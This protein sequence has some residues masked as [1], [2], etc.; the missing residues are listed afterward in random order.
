MYILCNATRVCFIRN[1]NYN[2]KTNA[3]TLLE[4]LFFTFYFIVVADGPSQSGDGLF[5]AKMYL[6]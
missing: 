1:R 3:K 4:F 2:G 5:V 6:N